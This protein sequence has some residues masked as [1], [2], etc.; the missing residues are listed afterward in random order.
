MQM[1][2]M[3]RADWNRI[4]ETYFEPANYAPRDEVDL[5]NLRVGL[6]ITED[7]N[8]VFWGKNVT[9]ED[10]VTEAVNPAGAIYFTSLA[11]Y[12]VEMTKRF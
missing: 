3:F 1:E 7:L 6:D 2:A 5:L 4:G 10:Y 8:L 11:T 12:G 9:N